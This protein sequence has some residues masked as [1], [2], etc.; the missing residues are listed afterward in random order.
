MPA[1]NWR[2]T[3][4]ITGTPLATADL[5]KQLEIATSD[6]SHDSHLAVLASAAVSYF[7]KQTRYLLG[8][9][10]VE[11]SLD[12]FADNPLYLP[13]RPFNSLADIQVNGT[14]ISSIVTTDLNSEPPRIYPTSYT[15]SATTE[16]IRNIVITGNAGQAVADIP[17]D[18]NVALRLLAA[19]WFEYREDVST[20]TTNKLPHG[21]KEIIDSYRLC[22]GY[23]LSLSDGQGGF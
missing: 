10:D 12:H 1:F 2:N 21:V 23:L 11:V 19:T 22:D 9:R 7:E 8:T 20:M 17:T 16:P 14:S 4:A 6:T 13:V 15:W 18:I 5:K 3:G